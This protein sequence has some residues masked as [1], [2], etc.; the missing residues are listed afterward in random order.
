MSAIIA[1][2]MLIILYFLGYRIYASFI[3]RKIAIPDKD[4]ITPA[5]SLNDGVDFYPAKKLVLLGHHFGSIAGAGPIIGPVIAVYYFGWLP[6]LLWICIGS[7]FIGSAHDYLTLMVSVRNKGG[8]ISNIAG[9]IMGTWTKVILAIFLWL[10]LVLV[11]SVFGVVAAR[12][13]LKEPEIV[14][15]TFLLIPISIL[16]GFFVYRK[17]VNV[18]LATFISLFLLLFSIWL[19]CLLPIE[20]SG[21][22]TAF[23][24]WFSLLMFYGLAAS[25]L[26]VW[27]LLQPRDYLATYI[28]FIGM[29][30]GFLGIFYSHT[31]LNSPAFVKCNSELGPIWPMLFVIIACG[32][33]SGFHSLVAGG[34]TSKQ[35]NNETEGKFIGYGGMILEGA[36]GTMA[37]LVVAAGLYWKVAPAGSDPDLIYQTAMGKSWIIAFS[38]GF[39]HL[40]EKLP[41]VSVQAAFLFPMFMLNC[42]VITSLDSATRLG[43]FIVQETLPFSVLKNRWFAGLVMIIPAVVLG[44]TNAWTAIW[45]IFGSANQLIATLTLFVIST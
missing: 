33:I 39:G 14:I 31:P 36:V 2:F 45:A 21:E 26:P 24:I 43:R 42:F 41:L 29:F 34:T 37:V 12:T 28:L 32:A 27:L 25:V 13:L 40:V 9:T 3:D 4:A 5:H 30:L 10:T 44:A 15:P 7:I 1:F 18:V 23:F 19:G 6:A 20:I 11:I 35:L 17:T 22:K 16:F 38:R 8:S